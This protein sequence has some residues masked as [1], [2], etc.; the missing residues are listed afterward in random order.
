MK[1]FLTLCIIVLALLP[2]SYLYACT[3]SCISKGDTVLFG[4][5]EDW[6][7]PDTKVWYVPAEKGKYGRVYFGFDGGHF[8]FANRVK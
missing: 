7:D 5:N 2:G 8:S 3:G 1:R 6:K 4:N